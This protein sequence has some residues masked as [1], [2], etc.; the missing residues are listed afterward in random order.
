[1]RPPDN[2]A[3]EQAQAAEQSEPQWVYMPD[4][5]PKKKHHWDK[6]EPGF[7]DVRGILVGKCPN[8]DALPPELKKPLLIL[9]QNRGCLHEVQKWLKGS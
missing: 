6:N 5:G 9:A 1:M 2:S 4:E 3:P 7:E 8:V